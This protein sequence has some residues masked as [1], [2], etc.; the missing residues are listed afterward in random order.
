MY[1]NATANST[2]KI[3]SMVAGLFL[4]SGSRYRIITIPKKKTYVILL[5]KKVIKTILTSFNKINAPSD[6]IQ[7]FCDFKIQIHDFHD[8]NHEFEKVGSS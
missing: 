4:Y 3:N 7:N 6:K 5:T 8:N 2:H 1:T